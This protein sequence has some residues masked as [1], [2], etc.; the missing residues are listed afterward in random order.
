MRLLRKRVHDYGPSILD[1]APHLPAGAIARATDIRR[2]MT[3]RY[4]YVASREAGWQHTDY[5]V[6]GEPYSVATRDGHKTAVLVQ[7]LQRRL[8]RRPIR[9]KVLL[10]HMS[11]IGIEPFT[12]ADGRQAW[13][14]NRYAFVLSGPK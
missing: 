14:N 10:L 8:L 7:R 13:H 6:I 12:L 1:H 5:I 11:H 3:I 9:G 4:H 2:G